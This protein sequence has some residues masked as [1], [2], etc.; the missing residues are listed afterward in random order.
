MSYVAYREK[1]HENN[2]KKKETTAKHKPTWNY[3]SG[4]PNKTARR[5]RA[6][7]SNTFLLCVAANSWICNIKVRG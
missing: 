3:R 2:A 1:K 5:Y 6:D 7:S 4:W